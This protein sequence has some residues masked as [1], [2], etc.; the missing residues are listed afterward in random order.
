VALLYPALKGGAWR[1]Q[2]G[3]HHLRK[4]KFGYLELTFERVKAELLE[5][6]LFN[7]YEIPLSTF[8]NREL[9]KKLDLISGA[10]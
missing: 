8:I 1:P 10:E 3:Q 6:D 7:I 5:M 4:I 9:H 2:M